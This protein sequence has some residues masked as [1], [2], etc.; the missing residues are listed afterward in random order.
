[1]A[2]RAKL[3]GVQAY[4][5]F[6][7]ANGVQR[8]VDAGRA[9]FRLGWE[10]PGFQLA[11]RVEQALRE[12]AY[13]GVESSS[14]VAGTVSALCNLHLIDDSGRR[15]ERTFVYSPRKFEALVT[16]LERHPDFACLD[17]NT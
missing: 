3:A 14:A 6:D 15:R 13:L 10:M 4:L 5:V 1:M 11:E 17:V 2:S 16:N 8:V 7:L 9:F 12:R